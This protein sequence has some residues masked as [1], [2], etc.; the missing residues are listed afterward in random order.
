MFC[1]VG[2]IGGTNA[3]FAVAHLGGSRPTL[4]DPMQ[5]ACADF[6]TAAAAIDGYLDAASV[7]RPRRA[8]IAV[9]GPVEAS[10]VQATNSGWR[11]SE[12]ELLAE[13]FAVAR[14]LNDFGALAYAAPA[15]LPDDLAVLGPPLPAPAAGTVAIVGAGTGF[16]VAALARDGDASIPMSTEGG[17][18]AFAPT[19]DIEVSILALLG[20]RFGRVSVER[21]LSGPGLADLHWALGQ[22]GGGDH[23]PLSASDI[24]AQGLADADSACAETL[25]RFCAIYGAVAGDIALALGARGGVYLGGGIA[26]RI[27]AVLAD[28]GFRRRFE[29]KG[30]FSTFMAAIPTQVILHPYAALLGA[31][32]AAP[33][34]GPA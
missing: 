25:R 34:W 5:F 19:D 31:A 3:R 6:E 10:A 23:P 7:P 21:I 13:G 24:V 18:I 9:A 11:L 8:C 20:G 28:G 27:L 2:D 17:H 30:R 14:V 26:P 4:C 29:A 12:A 1:L 16:G 32:V 22:I 15:F 33:Q